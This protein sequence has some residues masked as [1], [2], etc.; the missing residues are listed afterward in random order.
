MFLRL[1]EI[2]EVRDLLRVDAESARVGLGPPPLG[3]YVEVK[4]ER[5][6]GEAANP[7]RAVIPS[8]S[9]FAIATVRGRGS[10]SLLRGM[11]TPR[12]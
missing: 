2:L 5:R 12:P 8:I 7:T 10:V 1:H 3:L 4:L 11:N 9:P 6:D